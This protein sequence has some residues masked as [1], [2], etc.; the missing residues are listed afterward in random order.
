L[1]LFVIALAFISVSAQADFALTDEMN[2]KG[3]RDLKVSFSRS[4]EAE[5]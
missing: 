1:K 5:E 2:D 4:V 3:V